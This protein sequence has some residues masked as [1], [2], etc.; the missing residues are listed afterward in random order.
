MLSP[1]EID[2]V[3]MNKAAICQAIEDAT[4][5]NSKGRG[6]GAQCWHEAR[7]AIDFLT[8]SSG[9]CVEDR[10]IVCG[11]AGIDP[12]ELKKFAEKALK[13]NE[14]WRRSDFAGDGLSQES[15]D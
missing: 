1:D 14:V 9:D 8:A 15:G 6:N 7:D 13:N 10:E 3:A 2:I 11:I 4:T 5:W 12:D